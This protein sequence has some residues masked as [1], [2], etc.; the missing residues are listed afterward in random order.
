MACVLIVTTACRGGE[1]PP[2]ESGFGAE[3][4]SSESAEAERRRRAHAQAEGG[5]PIIAE[6]VDE[7]EREERPSDFQAAIREAEA[8]AGEQDVEQED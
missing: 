7:S 5:S 1:E 8:A 2:P 3:T 4:E 6:P